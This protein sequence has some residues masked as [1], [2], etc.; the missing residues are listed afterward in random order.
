MFL[1]PVKFRTMARAYTE[2]DS[3]PCSI[4]DKLSEI[5][6]PAVCR[7]VFRSGTANGFLCVSKRGSTGDDDHYC[8]VTNNRAISD[9]SIGSLKQYILDFYSVPNLREFRV[10]QEIIVSVWTGRFVDV[11]VIEIKQGMASRMMSEGARFLEMGP[12]VVGNNV[13][14]MVG[15]KSFGYGKIWKINE[16][17]LFH[18]GFTN[19]RNPSAPLVNMDGKV[20]GIENGSNSNECNEAVHLQSVLNLYLQQKNLPLQS[21][22]QG[23]IE[24]PKY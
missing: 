5:L 14:L 19:P 7:I 15:E 13:L 4:V 10:A 17:K 3:M 9:I 22:R 6:K 16:Y 23:F 20:V 12:A 21:S 18:L 2:L 24:L 11:T 1:P 8:L